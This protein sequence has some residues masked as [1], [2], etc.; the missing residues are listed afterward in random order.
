M[1]INELYLKGDSSGRTVNLVSAPEYIDQRAIT[2]GTPEDI[3][4]PTGAV[5]VIF[6]SEVNFYVKPNG[7][8]ARPTGDVTDGTAW[9]INPVGYVI[10]GLSTGAITKFRVDTGSTGIV[11]AKFYRTAYNV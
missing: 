2:A 8:G 4:V 7:S 10:D 9:D 6:A 11:A 1:P 3:T 5:Y